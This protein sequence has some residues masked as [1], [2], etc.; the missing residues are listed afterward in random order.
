MPKV[1]HPLQCSTDPDLDPAL[2]R[3]RI[4]L[5]T[6]KRIRIQLPK[7]LILIQL[8]KIMRIRISIPVSMVSVHSVGTFPLLKSRLK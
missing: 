2:I 8:P 3:I 5:F 1:A 7:M 4:H 6:L